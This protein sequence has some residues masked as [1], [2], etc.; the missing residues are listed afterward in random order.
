MHYQL[1]ARLQ[2]NTIF[3]SLFITAPERNKDYWIYLFYRDLVYMIIIL[4]KLH[5]MYI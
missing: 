5:S 4:H 1:D 3:Q 2:T